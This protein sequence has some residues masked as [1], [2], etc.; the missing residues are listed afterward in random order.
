[1]KFTMFHR[2]KSEDV[3]KTDEL[4]NSVGIYKLKNRMISELS[5]G[6]FQKML[7]ARALGI[8]FIALTP[9]YPPDMSSY[10]FG[11][12]LSVTTK[13]HNSHGCSCY[14]HEHSS[15]ECSCHSLEKVLL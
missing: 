5:G 10:L 14:N 1:M 4:L 6:E 2:Y 8:L 11:S 12:I 9:G 3:E 15:H 13:G 7:I